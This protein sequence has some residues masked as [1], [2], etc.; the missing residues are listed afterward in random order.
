MGTWW[1]HCGDKGGEKRNWPPY[2]IC[3]WLRISVLSSRHSPTYES[4][5]YYLCVFL[6][7][8]KE[9]KVGNAPPN[10]KFYTALLPH[11]ITDL[12]IWTCN[13]I[14]LLNPRSDGTRRFCPSKTFPP[15]MCLLNILSNFGCLLYFG[16]FLTLE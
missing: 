10:N 14:R 7:S 2:F 5:R 6:H 3:R 1:Q 4:I 16:S 15:I 9:G 11:R 13:Q 8:C 12:E